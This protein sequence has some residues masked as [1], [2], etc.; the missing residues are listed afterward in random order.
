MSRKILYIAVLVLSFTACIKEI[1]YQ[2]DNNIPKLPVLH[3][4]ISPDSVVTADCNISTGVFASAQT[5]DNAVFLLQ[6]NDSIPT[7][8]VAMGTGDYKFPGLNYK[9]GDIFRLDAT[10]PGFPAFGLE[11][12]IPNSII[13]EKA[14]TGR[15]L[16]PGSG[17]SFFINI[18]F[19]DSALYDNFYR[20]Q[21]FKISMK[22][23]YNNNGFIID[24]FISKDIISIYSTELPV[25]ENNFNNYSSREIN[26]SDATFNGVKSSLLFYTADKLLPGKM[27]KP[28]KLE[29]HLQN[30]DK[31]LYQYFN[32]RN[33]HI[34][35]QQSISQ[36]PG[37]V[38]GNLPGALGVAGAYTE[39]VVL[40]DLI[41]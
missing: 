38:L 15:L 33:A 35:Q 14:D 20:L 32:T 30:I 28:M 37:A 8:A 29:V 40:L 23:K 5:I 2:P 41:K 19:T 7:N 16:V 36:V 6:Q 31:S 25:A 9:A 39:D 1:P 21:I 26:F 3:I 10:I 24:S 11:G 27:E 4:F 18:T 34:W 12:K 13:I 22:Y 17:N